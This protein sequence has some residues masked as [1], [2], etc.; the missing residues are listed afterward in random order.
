MY[1]VEV[2]REKVYVHCFKTGA[3]VARLCKLSI[4][5]SKDPFK[6]GYDFVSK[7]VNWNIFKEKVK[8]ILGY[9]IEINKPKL[10]WDLQ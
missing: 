6:D 5:I 3:T 8:E 2:T 9:E 7:D 1:Q 10:I 4:E